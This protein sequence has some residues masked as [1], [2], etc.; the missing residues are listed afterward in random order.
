MR[1]RLG[2]LAVGV[3]LLAIGCEEEP[4]TV[5]KM[6]AGLAMDASRD[7]AKPDAGDAGTGGGGLGSFACRSWTPPAG[8]KC[9]GSHC[10]ET[11]AEVKA[12]ATAT[13]VCKKDEEFEQFCSLSAVT[14]TEMCTQTHYAS[15]APGI[16]PCVAA[17]LPAYT[18]ACIDCYVSSALCAAN[19]CLVE[20]LGNSH[21]DACENCRIN[22]G[23]ISGFY[24][25]AGYKNPIP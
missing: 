3:F 22:N 13:S 10:L 20:C 7:A 14:I 17:M 5:G 21:T 4:Q 24:D 23:C 9:G 18:S 25:C 11:L 19:Y 2:A 16:K 6:D 15:G 8:D 1:N 12:N